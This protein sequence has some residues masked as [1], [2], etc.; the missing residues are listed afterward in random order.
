MRRSVLS[1]FVAAAALVIVQGPLPS[2]AGE[3]V[4]LHAECGDVDDSGR[5]DASD[6]LRLLQYAVQTSG[7]EVCCPGCPLPSTTLVTTTTNTTTTTLRFR[8]NGDGTF[9]DHHTGLMWEKKTGTPGTSAYCDPTPCP[10]PNDVNNLYRWSD[11]GDYPD[12]G[13]FMDF[14]AK[15]N[16]P[17]G[18]G[19]TTAGGPTVTGCFAEHCDWRLPT[20]EELQTILDA[21]CSQ[22]GCTVWDKTDTAT[23]GPT[24]SYVYWSTSTYSHGPWSNAWV[25]GFGNGRAYGAIKTI[26]AFVRAVRGGS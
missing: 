9:T 14:L 8:D 15:L 18:P 26:D 16:A 24:I 6:A 12:G 7:V 3:C 23:F 13:A 17:D 2:V 21:N 1:S 20:I 25:G 4:T 11:T 19:T 22:G 10:D 5:V